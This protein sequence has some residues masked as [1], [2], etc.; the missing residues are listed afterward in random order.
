[1]KNLTVVLENRPGALAAACEA[2]GQEGINIEGMCCFASQ[3]VAM[4]YVAVHDGAAARRA[5]ERIGLRVSEE[6]DVVPLPVEDKPGSAA[7]L[8][9]SIADAGVNV[10]LAYLA[11]GPRIVVGSDEIDKIRAVL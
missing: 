6:R 3:G 1:M 5:I 4:L 9:R 7:R 2:M 8:L 10:Q 11:T